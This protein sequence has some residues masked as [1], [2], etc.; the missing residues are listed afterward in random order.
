MGLLVDG[1]WQD[2]WNVTTSGAGIFMRRDSQNTRSSNLIRLAAVLVLTCACVPLASLATAQHVSLPPVNL[3]GTSFLDGLGGPGLLLQSSNQYYTSDRL[4]GPDGDALSGN[5]SVQSAAVVAH[6]A[7]LSN[8]KLFG[9]YFGGEVLLPLVTVDVDTD[10]GVHGRRMGLGDLSFSPFILQWTDRT[11]FGRPMYQRFTLSFTVPTGGYRA[12]RSVNIGT[13]VVSINPYYAFTWLVDERWET[14]WRF[15]YLWVSAN[16]DPNPAY[17]ADRIQ[18][19]Q[20]VHF[21]GAV[22]YAFTPRVRV[23]LAGYYLKQMTDQKI[24]GR[25]EY[26]SKE[27]VAGIGPG[28]TLQHDNGLTLTLNSYVEF[29]AENRAEGTRLVLRLAK[30]F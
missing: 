16:D 21:N 15:H 6:I 28:L 19:G 12:D 27:R 25:T 22:S 4:T 26:G 24:D 18:A 3:G 17:E 30:V 29:G 5:N 20:A 11:L 13:N 9:A 14:S 2:E 8:T 10:F 7:L 23:G 1:Q